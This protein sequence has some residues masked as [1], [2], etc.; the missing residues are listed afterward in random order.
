MNVD[1]RARFLSYVISNFVMR[2]I[3]VEPFFVLNNPDQDLTPVHTMTDLADLA[4]IDWLNMSLNNKM[5][6]PTSLTLSSIITP[7]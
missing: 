2:H 6:T 5:Y 1:N 7:S 3:F 4:Q